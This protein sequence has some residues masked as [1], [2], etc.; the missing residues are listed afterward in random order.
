MN[1]LMLILN[2]YVVKSSRINKQRNKGKYLKT[3]NLH[4]WLFTPK[5]CAFL[6]IK[7]DHQQTIRPVV[8]SNGYQKGYLTEFFHQGT[9]DDSPYVVTKDAIAFYNDIGGHVRI[10]GVYQRSTV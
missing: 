6:C 9:R 2:V 10:L 3:G 8:T 4:K 5:G 1:V 7:K